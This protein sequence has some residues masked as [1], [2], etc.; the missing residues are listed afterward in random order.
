MDAIDRTDFNALR[1]IE[2]PDALGA[3][4]R[5]DDVDL[6][7]LG[8]GPVGAL[9][10]A[11][12]AVDAFIGDEK[13]HAAYPVRRRRTPGR[14][15]NFALRRAATTGLTKLETSPPR[16]AI[17]RTIVEDMKRYCSA[18]VRKRVSTSG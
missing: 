18:G 9:G 12:V 4:R 14:L 1:R 5:I 6:D 17:S 7:T 15:P 11:D 10:L 16:L 13:G 8:D 2:V 3:L